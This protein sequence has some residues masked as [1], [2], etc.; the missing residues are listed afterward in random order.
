[1]VKAVLITVSTQEIIKKA[2]YP[3]IEIVPIDSLDSDLEWLIINKLDQPTYDQA[4]EKIVRFEEITT[5]PHPIYTELNQYRIGHNIVTLTES[6]LDDLEDNEADEKYQTHLEK[7]LGFHRRSYKKVWKR[8]NKDRDTNNKLTKSKGRK[9]FRW[10]E[11]VWNHL[12]NGDFREAEKA[13]KAV[14]VDND[15]E[16]QTEPAMLNTVQ[17]FV[18]LIHTYYDSS[19]SNGDNDYDL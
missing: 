10:F 3:S 13:I 5:D 2:N 7:G 8:V 1:M 11:P 14:L 17:W 15:T 9:L 4:T 12:K 18:D 6:E 16:L 19:L